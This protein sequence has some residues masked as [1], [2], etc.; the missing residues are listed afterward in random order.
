MSTAFFA[1]VGNLERGQ[2]QLLYWSQ[3][4]RRDVSAHP[5]NGRTMSF[6]SWVIPRWCPSRW[7]SQQEIRA[8]GI[9]KE[10]HLQCHT[11]I[12]GIIKT[13]IC[14]QKAEQSGVLYNLML[15]SRQS[16][17]ITQIFLTKC[18]LKIIQKTLHQNS[19]S[20]IFFF[21]WEWTSN[22]YWDDVNFSELKLLLLTSFTICILLV[23]FFLLFLK[24]HTHRNVSRPF[25]CPIGCIALL[26]LS[27]ERQDHLCGW[28]P[29]SS[30]LLHNHTSQQW[31][32]RSWEFK[33]T[34][35]LAISWCSSSE[36]WRDRCPDWIGGFQC[37]KKGSK[38]SK[39]FGPPLRCFGYLFE[40]LKPLS[41]IVH[42]IHQTA[43][44]G[45]GAHICAELSKKVYKE[46]QTKTMSIDLYIQG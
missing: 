43:V 46:N 23:F 45:Q 16:E 7:H 11:T 20:K 12:P 25:V 26:F 1:K 19:L 38:A 36:S 3:G 6:M 44:E 40:P 13:T 21:F 8:R 5:G 2:W 10:G 4:G 41:C 31:S 14:W 33:W 24:K 34:N 37:A 30:L 32:H 35:V 42:Q 18:F 9:C 15:Y 27:Q 22:G 29:F 39:Q 17:C 28:L